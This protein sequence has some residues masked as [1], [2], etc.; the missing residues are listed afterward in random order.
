MACDPHRFFS[1]R[2]MIGTLPPPPASGLWHMYNSW[3]RSAAA[4]AATA[5]LAW[6]CGGG[7]PRDPPP[8]EGQGGAVQIR[9][10]ERLGWI[11][12]APSESAIRAHQF[13]LLVD[14]TPAAM[15]EVQCGAPA[16]TGYDCS[17]RLPSMSPGRHVLEVVSTWNGQQSP[18][19][20]GLTVMVL[21]AQQTSLAAEFEAAPVGSKSAVTCARG[22]E[23]DC[24]D[25]SMVA[26]GL[27][28]VAALTATADG[29]LL[30][31]EEQRVLRVVEHDALLPQ[32][33][34]VVARPTD[35]IVG[36]AADPALER[37]RVIFVAWT[38][39]G[40]DGSSSSLNVSR[41][42]EVGGTLGEGATIV[43]G[44]PFPDGAAA[45]LEV[46]DSGLLYLAVPTLNAADR[47]GPDGAFN[48]F[49]LRFGRDGDVPRTNPRA[50][51]VFAI[52]LARPSG[53]RFDGAMRLMWIA[54]TDNSADEATASFAIDAPRGVPWPLQPQRA[55]AAS[56]DP[57][58][59]VEFP[60]LQA[61]LELV[62][63]PDRRLYAL[64][65][66]VD[67]TSSILLLTPR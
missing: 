18:R 7:S 48:G 31:I 30:F 66:N 39:A 56:R 49:V 38:E 47:R 58:D 41:F 62:E 65:R 54:G 28:D 67:Q 42:R 64:V 46:D 43:T 4:I 6:A 16:P 57:F 61:I 53:L 3:L 15:S 32:P 27:R 19:S 29:R 13:T 52:G 20:S 60:G 25:V 26:G 59:I 34:Y 17:G 44:L 1:T 23:S 36:I 35:R 63:C 14:G 55:A 40:A 9:G 12:A 11:Q 22:S 5:L 8:G 33:G 2:R 50:S 10:G 37:A 24:Y 21:A 45:P 51:P